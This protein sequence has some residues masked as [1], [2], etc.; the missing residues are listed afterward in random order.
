MLTEGR[1]SHSTGQMLLSVEEK[2]TT[3]SE[4]E[5]V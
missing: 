2:Q 3:L 4:Q 1:L 5:V